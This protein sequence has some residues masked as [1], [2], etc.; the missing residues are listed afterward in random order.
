VD[1]EGGYKKT[2]RGFHSV[3]FGGEFDEEHKAGLVRT[4][5]RDNDCGRAGE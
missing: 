5:H 3:E 1:G 4:V 2:E